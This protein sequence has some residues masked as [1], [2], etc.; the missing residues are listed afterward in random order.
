[1]S[2]FY[3]LL[4]SVVFADDTSCSFLFQTDN[5][6]QYKLES[7]SDFIK[8]E[9]RPVLSREKKNFTVTIT[10]TCPNGTNTSVT[11]NM[12]ANMLYIHGIN[13]ITLPGDIVKY[14][15]DPLEISKENFIKKFNG[16]VNFNK[17][18]FKE[19]QSTV[20]MFAFV[21]AEAA[22][23]EDVNTT[24]SKAFTGDC[25][26]KWNDF[27]HLLRRWKT[28]SIFANSQGLVGKKPF[29][30]GT[31]A[32][33]IAPITSQAVQ[34]YNKVVPN[35]WDVVV[36]KYGKPRVGDIKIEIPVCAGV[37]FEKN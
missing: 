1:M 3:L 20:K 25:T 22:R 29:T 23:F 34:Q 36:G 21:I 12:G 33:L 17:L 10:R 32:F 16:A 27:S 35:G 8:K 30:G 7:I 31:R 26:Y 5:K 14:T 15:D 13:G 2:V 6:T 11:L 19:K 37:G 9:V 24:V 4:T 28:L 18:G